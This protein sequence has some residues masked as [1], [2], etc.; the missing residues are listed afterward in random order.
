MIEAIHK[1]QN[2]VN[3]KSKYT[4]GTKVD[5]QNQT[6]EMVHIKKKWNPNALN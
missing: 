2:Q 3:D 5:N 1:K 6:N 4:I